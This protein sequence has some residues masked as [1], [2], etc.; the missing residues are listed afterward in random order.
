MPSESYDFKQLQH[1]F[2]NHIRTRG[3]A[4]APDGIPEHRLSVYRALFY[5]NITGF[6]DG[7]FPVCSDVLGERWGELSDL[8]FRTH[9]CETPYFAEICQEFLRF[10][11]QDYAGKDQ[12]PAWL[13]ELAH[14]EWLELS[15]DITVSDLP[16]FN[17]DGDVIDGVPVFAPAT[18]AFLYQYPV[19]TISTDNATPEPVH[20]AIIV[21]RDADEDVRFVHTNPI[22]LALLSLLKEQ[23]LTGRQAVYGLLEAQ[24]IAASEAAVQGGVS[25]L[26]QW[27]AQ[28]LIL[29]TLT[30]SVE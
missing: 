2:S 5:N 10:L 9:R 25:I 8:F 12:D 1:Q 11:E 14:Y 4:P 20:T 29:G 7:T 17:P 30:S 13:Y 26:S 27:K 21:Y 18:E 6:L 3:D 15:V 24:G 16:I 22:T 19:H 28:G 23:P